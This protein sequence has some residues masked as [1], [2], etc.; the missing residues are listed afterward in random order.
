MREYR[1]R[2]RYKVEVCIG[3]TAVS[4]IPMPI[5]LTVGNILILFLFSCHILVLAVFFDLTIVRELYITTIPMTESVT[6]GV[7]MYVLSVNY[8][9]GQQVLVL[10]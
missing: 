4:A 9:N 3:T 6:V 8:P 7:D 1:N 10:C 5:Y 2:R